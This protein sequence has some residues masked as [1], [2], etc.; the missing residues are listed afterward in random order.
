MPK[1]PQT[2][3]WDP[4]QPDSEPELGAITGSKTMEV[5]QRMLMPAKWTRTPTIRENLASWAMC[6]LG[7]YRVTVN[8]DVLRGMSLRPRENLGRRENMPE[9]YEPC[10]TWI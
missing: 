4:C 6:L 8:D 10:E 1:T 9:L 7:K 2:A 5:V 3:A